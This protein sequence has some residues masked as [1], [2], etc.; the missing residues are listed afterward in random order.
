MLNPSELV[1]SDTPVE[2]VVVRIHRGY[3]KVTG[4]PRSDNSNVSIFQERL[5]VQSII[6]SYNK[7]L[8]RGITMGAQVGDM[9][10]GE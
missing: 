7:I 10:W 4:R 5:V 3:Q 9:S 8:Y 1:S 6:C 2:S